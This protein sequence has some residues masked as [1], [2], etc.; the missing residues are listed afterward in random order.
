M[1]KALLIIA[2]FITY[3]TYAQKTDLQ[4]ISIQNKPSENAAKQAVYLGFELMN[5]DAAGYFPLQLFDL[6]GVKK[7]KITSNENELFKDFVIEFNSKGQLANVAGRRDSLIITYKNNVP[8]KFV[9]KSQSL[10][11]HY[12]GD[13]VI[14]T[15]NKILAVYTLTGDFLLN[16]KTSALSENNQKIE[17]QILNSARL[18][19]LSGDSIKLVSDQNNEP[20]YTASSSHWT[21][22]FTRE[23]S[24]IDTQNTYKIKDVY[25]NDSRGDLILD[26]TLNQ[27]DKVQLVYKMKDGRPVNIS[28]TR[29]FLSEDGVSVRKSNSGTEIVKISYEYF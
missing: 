11:F 23:Y 10:E 29:Q 1:K 5:P 6:K 20:R 3:N 8:F 17:N 28:N 13:T 25:Y 4:Q 24:I 14:L 19:K 7:M 21:L 16:T 9:N 18:V 27:E 22:P 26:K 15:D 12:S 2:V